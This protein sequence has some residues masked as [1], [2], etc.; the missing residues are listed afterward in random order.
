MT[1]DVTHSSFALSE[2]E[3][4]LRHRASTSLSTNESFEQSFFR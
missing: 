2:V 1:G 4:R 3:G